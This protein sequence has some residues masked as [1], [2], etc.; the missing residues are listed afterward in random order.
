MA[1][2]LVYGH[3]HQVVQE[4]R[5]GILHLNPGECCGW[6]AGKSTIATLDTDSLMVET[7]DLRQ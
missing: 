2:V 7:V 1:D 6:V 5:K 4:T 3:T